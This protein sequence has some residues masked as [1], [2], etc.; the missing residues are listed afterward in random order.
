ML[1]APAKI[2]ELAY[3]TTVL[4]NTH[5]FGLVSDGETPDGFTA[6]F[7]ITGDQGVL[8][9]PA[10]KGDKGD[11][12]SHAFALRLQLSTIDDPLNLPQTLGATDA[13]IGKYWM[14][15]DVDAQGNVIGSSAYIWF[16]DH[17]RRM[18]MGSRGPAGP[19][20]KITPN[21]HWIAPEDPN[22]LSRVSSSGDPYSPQWDWWLNKEDIRG[23][24]GTPGPFR[25]SPDVLITSPQVGDGIFWDGTVG[26]DGFPIWKNMQPTA[27][28]MRMWTVPEAA[29][30]S[31]E[32][33][34]TRAT[35]GSFQIPSLPFPH[36]IAV[37]AHLKA[38]G[39]E[40]DPDPLTIGCEVRLGNP[41]SGQL[42][43]RGFGSSIG[44]VTLIPHTSEPGAPSV[45]MTP[46]NAVCK[47]VANQANPTA[48]TVYINLYNDGITG[49]YLFNPADA[50]MFI[51][52]QPV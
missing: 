8:V 50:Q 14:I 30:T 1:T 31:F 47:I 29:F 23:P 21:F 46:D 25:T 15:D 45:S 37:F 12:G 34:S 33:M 24:Q 38:Y 2:G 39:I 6:T 13:D 26:L 22:Q 19:V 3:I 43:A 27:V 35:I 42:V 18:M 4:N 7:E 40:L 51:M 28:G 36:K 49:V 44:Q 16:G 48:R 52:A 5:V 11:S 10:L 32:G 20:P 41:T 17:Y 9:I